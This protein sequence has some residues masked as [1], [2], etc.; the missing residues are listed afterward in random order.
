MKRTIWS[1]VFLCLV[2]EGKTQEVFQREKRD[3]IWL[4]GYGGGPSV[5]QPAIKM[6]FH[7][8]PVWIGNDPKHLDFDIT[9][10]NISDAEGNLLFY[11]NGIAIHNHLNELMENG[12]GLNPDPFTDWW[13]HGGYI[14][15]QSTLILPYPANPSLYYLLHNAT[16]IASEPVY[17][18]NYVALKF[19]YSLIDMSANEGAGKV[20]LKNNLIIQ[21]SIDHGKIVATRHANGRDWWI[22]SQKLFSNRYYR[23]LLSTEGLIVNQPQEVGIPTASGLGQAVFSPD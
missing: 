1:L 19:Y 22:L 12:D 5:L 23:M 2:V 13:V 15:V 21:D 4:L 10:A 6:D 14:I 8:S 11:T 18:S 3:Y 16:S 17:G 7:Y 9:N 20:I